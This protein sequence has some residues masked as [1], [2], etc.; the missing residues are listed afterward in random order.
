MFVRTYYLIE[1]Q[2]SKDPRNKLKI[3]QDQGIDNSAAKNKTE[4]REDRIPVVVLLCTV[5][6][7]NSC[8]VHS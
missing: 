4:Q 3:A 2:R 6:F 8:T 5:Q 7:Y 1:D